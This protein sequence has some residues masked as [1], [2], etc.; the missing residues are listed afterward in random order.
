MSERKVTV[1]V[2]VYNIEQYL[3][4]FFDCLRQQTF[5]DYEALIIDDGSADN[6]A[7]IC[8]AHAEKDD[9]IRVI[10]VEHVGIS[11][12][13]NL[14]IENLRTEFATSLD[15]DD[16]F[17]KDYL[18]H[19][20]EAQERYGADLTLSNVVYVYEDGREKDRFSPRKEA[21]YTKEDFSGL[22]PRLIEEG[23]LN[24]L[25]A[26]L[27]KSSL[28]KK[29]R[30]EPDVR[31]GSDTMINAMVLRYTE[32]IAV[33]ED[34]DYYYVQYQSR[35]VTS[36]Q[37]AD[38]FKRLYRINTFL[39]NELDAGG[40]L[41]DEMLRVT[42]GRILMS[43]SASLYR[44]AASDAPLPEKYRRAEEIIDSEEY[45]IP[46]RRQEEYGNLG[47]F[48]F[49]PVAP[50]KGKEQIDQICGLI[51][52]EKKNKRLKKLRDM[53]PDALFNVWHSAKVKL[54]IARKK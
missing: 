46:Y 4:R 35:S 14:A 13:R 6:S 38:Y 10:S 40:Y 25:Y 24:F 7:K 32:S 5:T 49:T 52:E 54:G 11:A 22:L 26:K 21:F 53:C 2:T 47:S 41:D 19:L 20:I 15:G 39:M 31:Q 23:R 48:T 12:A 28:L 42:D 27:Y 30:L 9:R 36:Y 16:Y 51:K 8:M 43:A 37:G 44:I 18:K 1:I 17:D 34:Y 29:A 33:I 45:L 50:G 3:E